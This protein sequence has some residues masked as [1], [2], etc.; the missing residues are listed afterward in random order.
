MVRGIVEAWNAAGSTADHAEQR[1]ADTVLTRFHGVADAAL[2]LENPLAGGGI[3]GQ[4]GGSGSK[5]QQ[6]DN[7]GAPHAT[8]SPPSLDHHFNH[9][10]GRLHWSNS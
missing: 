4:G 2:R 7:R 8:F 9:P 10:L 5:E 1:R 6:S 3:G